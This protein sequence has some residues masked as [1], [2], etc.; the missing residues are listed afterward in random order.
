MTVDTDRHL[1]RRELEVL[2]L[3]G[4]GLT[5]GQVAGR[6]WLTV[7]T[8]NSHTDSA[9]AKL[10][11]H[12]TIDAVRVALDAGLIPVRVSHA[13]DAYERWLAELPEIDGGRRG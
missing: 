7:A 8:V 2:Q 6:L 5:A 13:D 10:R 11:V 9:R 12:T 1:T 3:I 4:C